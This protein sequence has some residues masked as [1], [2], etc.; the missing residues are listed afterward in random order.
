[1]GIA[2]LSNISLAGIN[3][4]TY[5]TGVVASFAGDSTYASSGGT[6]SLTVSP[7]T[8]SITVG[9]HAP[10]HA[11]YNYQFTVGATASSGLSVSYSSSGVCT[12]NGVTFTMTSGTGTCTVLYDQAGN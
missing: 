6:N 11:V 7:A 1:S 8:Q 4:G 5:A 12:N 10:V 2:S 3:A 9:T